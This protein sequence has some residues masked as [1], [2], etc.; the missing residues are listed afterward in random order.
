MKDIFKKNSDEFRRGFTAVCIDARASINLE[1]AS[2]HIKVHRS[3]SKVQLAI[4]CNCLGSSGDPTLGGDF[5]GNV[6]REGGERLK[7]APTKA[8][9]VVMNFINE[10]N[11]VAVN[12]LPVAQ[13]PVCS[14]QGH[15]GNS[16]IDYILVP[17][18]MM[19]Q[20]ASCRTGRNESMNTSDHLPIEAVLRIDALPRSVECKRKKQRIRWD[21]ANEKCIKD[22][23]QAPLDR[24]LLTLREKLLSDRGI[25]EGEVDTSFDWVIKSIH[26]AASSIPRTKYV[27]H[28]KPY[29]CEELSKLKKEKMF[30]FNRWKVEGRTMDNNNW[31]RQMMKST[32]KI[33]IKRIRVLSKEYQNNLVAEAASKA[34]YN[35]EDFWKLMKRQKSNKRDCINAVKNTEGKVVYEV[36][37]VLDVWRKH[38]DKLSSPRAH[39]HFNQE[40]FNNVNDFVNRA[41]SGHDT[42]TFT[43]LPFSEYEMAAAISKLNSNKA[44][45]Y[46]DI[47]SEHVKFAGPTLV[48]VLCL[49]YNKCVTL[50]YIPCNFRKGVQVPL[51]KGKNTCSLDPDNYRGITLLTT[52]NKLFEVLIWG[53]IQKW[54]FNERVIS[55]SQGATRKGFSCVH[56][57]LTL[58]ETISKVRECNKK[59][60]VAYYDVSKAFDSVWTDGLFFQLHKLGITGTLWR[61]L[62]KG[63]QDFRCCVRIADR[64]SEWFKMECGIHQGGYLS[65]VKYTAFID[66][67]IED[68]NK[69]ELCSAIYKIPSSPVGYADDLAASTVSKN[70]MDQVMDKVYQHGCDWRYAFN[71]SKSAVL[72]YGETP[73][74][75]RIGNIYRMFSLGG[76]RVM[77][78]Q[79]YDHMGVKSCVKGDTHVR[80]EEK[81]S[82]ARKALNMATNV[83]IRRGGLNLNTCNVIYWAVVIP[84]LLFGCEIWLIKNKDIEILN[85]FQRYAARRIQR[86]HSRALNAT[87]CMC[88][89]WMNIVNV[90]IARKLIFIRT[91]MVM[92]EFMPIKR[93]FLERLKEFQVDAENKYDSPILQILQYCHEYDLMDRVRQMGTGSILSKTAWKKLV[94]EKCWL[95]EHTNHAK[96]LEE[97]HNLDLIRMVAPTPG[98][99]IWW[100]IADWNQQYMRRCENM[101][102]LL[103]HA[104]LLK[105]DDGRLR[106]A[107]FGTRCCIRCEIAAYDDARHLIMQCAVMEDI[108]IEMYNEIDVIC[109]EF[110]MNDV[111]PIL[112]GGKIEGWDFPEMIPIWLITCTHISRMYYRALKYPYSV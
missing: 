1:S 25:N 5:N 67:L 4:S 19:K 61:L 62:F 73:H 9:K 3:I 57:A 34:E 30:W 106:R 84:T 95:I 32:K 29:W 76:S 64:E 47:T 16:C 18:Y 48:S 42:C 85:A 92:D 101:V 109:K 21:K 58:Q 74:K 49:L 15:N 54:W 27:K 99:S 63:Y 82:K 60:F 7:G 90:V 69:S 75:S 96:I 107:P 78:K 35:R 98:Y 28:L 77:E 91:I 40:H 80:T 112:M 23:Y 12:L 53:R 97:D 79:Y 89:G 43:D 17:R 39:E 110:G 100:S 38:F 59:V 44:P 24:D 10:H 6:G 20:V 93:I 52:F 111:F 81:V 102:K 51:Y 68:L 14:Y 94:W 55:D 2:F 31:V 88:L 105:A 8:G 36:N 71:A 86:L 70:K 66:S 72:V 41:I 37:E 45:G 13:G 103:C 33:F 65:L 104:S 108:R 83:G 46:D 50:E 56:T 11:L 87:S 22:D 26:K